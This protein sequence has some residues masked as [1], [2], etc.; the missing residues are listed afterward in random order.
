VRAAAPAVVR[1]YL[2]SYPMPNG[3][4]L[5]AQRGEY[6]RQDTR[7]TDEHYAVARVDHQL[8]PNNRAFARYT[9]NDGEVT[10]PSRVNTGAITK[11][12]LQFLTAEV[13]TVRGAGL[14]NR[15][16]VGY[17][18]SRLDGY[19]YVLDGVTMPRLTFTDVDRGIGSLTIGGLSA[20]GGS[21]TNPKY[22]RFTNLQVSDTV[23]WVK[24][25]HN[26]QAGGHMEYQMY[27]LTSDFTTM[28]VFAFPSINDFLLVDRARTFN[29]SQPGSDTSRRLRQPVFGFFVQDDWQL[30]SDFTFNLGLR[31]EPTGNIT[32]ADGKLAQ[33]IDFGNP[34]AALG[35]VAVVDRIAENP[36]LRTFAPR[37]G[38]AWN[39]GGKGTTSVRG[40]AGVF[41]DLLTANTNFVQNT[42]VN[43]PPLVTRSRLTGTPALRIDFPDAF[44]T[45]AALLAGGG[46]TDL[47]GI[48]YDAD[49]PT[50][51]KWN[52]NVQ[53]QLRD[54]TSVEVGYTG[55][56][57]Y[58]L[59][60]QIFT[61]GREAVEIDGRLVVPA[62]Q[63]LRQP[64]FGRMR[65]RTSDGDSW[66]HGLTVGATQRM[67]DLQMQV[68]YTFG[69]SEDT[70]AAALGSGDYGTEG[71]GSRYLFSKDKGLSPFDV[72]HSFV[73][74]VNWAVPFGRNGGGAVAALIRNWS[75]GTLVRLKSGDPFSVNTGGLERGRQPN[76]PDF[77]DLC[78]GADANPVLGGPT[79]YFDPKAFCL[80]PAGVI[81]NA[82]R[83]SILGPGSATVDLMLS[84]GIELGGTRTLQLRFEMF[85]VLNR[86]NFA[87]P[88]AAIFNTDGSYRADAGRITSTVGTPR[89][90]QLGVKIVW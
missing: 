53:R 58:N 37:L 86:A 21:S 71:G 25:A 89:Q 2:D 16:Q 55:S 75:V 85:N 28:G 88:T 38:F 24:G 73:T 41:Y 65:L 7:R 35:D 77:P 3:R 39:V 15:V 11:T 23:S 8:S 82:P 42:A 44:V 66:Y 13:Q 14:V 48:Q 27:D 79:Q 87:L 64:N 59:F 57:G 78:P 72:R 47:E 74:S 69:K 18:G 22:H 26:L 29:A 5:D 81:G 46:S 76:A 43:N 49:Q 63:A 1:P 17:T 56:R 52:L 31:Y 4:T 9:F 10:D 40:G 67:T 50:V 80:Q 68:S 45:Q 54:R 62:G 90:M 30:R 6:V 33:L 84:R 34:A 20:W 12:R 36:S 19:D 51:L 70:G 60:R 32:D 61:N 83:N